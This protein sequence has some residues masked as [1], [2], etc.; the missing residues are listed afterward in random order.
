[1]GPGC[2]IAQ[3]GQQSGLFV[4]DDRERFIHAHAGL[5]QLKICAG[6]H[7]H[8]YR[9]ACGQI[10]L[11]AAPAEVCADAVRL[12]E[13][14]RLEGVGHAADVGHLYLNDVGRPPLAELFH[15]GERVTPFVCDDFRWAP[16][17]RKLAPDL[18][19]A[20]NLLR[21][22][23]VIRWGLDVQRVRGYGAADAGNVGG[24]AGGVEPEFRPDIAIEVK[25]RIGQ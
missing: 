15:V 20:L 21:R 13:H 9:N 5:R 11:H 14:Y 7:G 17:A 3:L 2:F 22:T 1:M 12:T 6:R 4:A 24:D 18:R 19:K 8:V 23:A 10:G 16:Q 25:V